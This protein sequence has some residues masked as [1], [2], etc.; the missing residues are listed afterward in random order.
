MTPLNKDQKQGIVERI[1]FM[2][3]ELKDLTDKYQN[4]DW[5]TYSVD[6]ETRRNIERIIE[7]LANA[8]ID[9]AKIMLAGET[10][11]IPGT[12]QEI[13]FKLGELSFVS[14]DLAAKIA[15]LAKT[16]NVLAH[17]YLDLKWDL[18]KPLVKECPI[19]LNDF[20]NNL[21]V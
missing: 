21:N 16:R 11:E 20:I 6:R 4:V 19:F 13:I 1:N 12:Y 7:N 17:Q 18:I 8:S 14:K 2:K 5:E 3:V 9:I 15:A 10:V